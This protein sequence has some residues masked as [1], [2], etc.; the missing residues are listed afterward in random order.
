M[1][2]PKSLLKGFEKSVETVRPDPKKRVTVFDE[3]TTGLCLLVTPRGRKTFTLVAR[4]PREGGK[5]GKQVWR[6]VGGY[7]DMTVAAART[8]AREGLVR[9]KAGLDPFPPVIEPEKPETF[10]DV[11][12]N[13]LK[14]HVRKEGQGEPALRSA[15]AIER[16]IDVF[17]RPKWGTQPFA[18]IKRSAVA[19]V[20]QGIADERGPVMADRALATLSTMFKQQTPFMPDEWQPPIMVGMRKT[21]ASEREG[22]RILADDE[23]ETADDDL[24]LFWKA[25]EAL[26]S[27]GAFARVLFLTG[28]RRS[29]VAAM[30]RA[31]LCEGIWSI[32]SEAREKGN[33]GR[34]RLPKLVLDIIEA[35]PEIEGNPY[36][37]AARGKRHVAGYGPLKKKLDEKVRELNAG[38]DIASWTL[39]DLRRTQRSLMARAG[40]D[41]R[42]AEKLQGRAVPGVER[43]YNRAALFEKKGDALEMLAALVDRIVNPPEGNVVSLAGRGR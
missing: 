34:I 40:V 23:T 10:N 37:F 42:V 16:Q 2:T 21:K 19:K 12:D 35:Q 1:P 39:H 36:V 28:Q 38:E 17:F 20:L 22:S 29:K 26:G 41:W 33:A 3:A 7:P 15:K 9:L 31:D 11:A 14:R 18:E 27:Q 32:P 43:V 25:T 13:F 24:R 5:P 8:K 30:Q 6:E 4:G